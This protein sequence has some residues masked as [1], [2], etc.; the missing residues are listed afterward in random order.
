[1]SANCKKKKK[2]K[3]KWYDDLTY[4]IPFVRQKLTKNP[5]NRMLMRFSKKSVKLHDDV[6]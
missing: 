5:S 4:K 2:T 1:M 6:I 3:I